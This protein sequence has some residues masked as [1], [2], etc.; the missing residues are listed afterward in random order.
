MASTDAASAAILESIERYAEKS[1]MSGAVRDW[2]E[3]WAWLNS[4]AQP[5]G[6]SVNVSVA[7]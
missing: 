5:H 7:K 2:A 1:H 3:A 6:G 4:P